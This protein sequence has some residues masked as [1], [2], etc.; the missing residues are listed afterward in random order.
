[1]LIVFFFCL[2]VCFFS[3]IYLKALEFKGY[4]IFRKFVIWDIK[5]YF[6]ILKKM[7][8]SRT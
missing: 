7:G 4:E 6:G 8:I 1:M 3:F 5:H 2:F